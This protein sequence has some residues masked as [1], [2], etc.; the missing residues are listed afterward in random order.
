[1][2]KT[3]QIE[4]RLRAIRN[5]RTI[6]RTMEMIA[7]SRFRRVHRQSAQASPA[8]AKLE[9]A[10]RDA[11][12]A[13]PVEHPLL[14]PGPGQAAL[15]VVLTSNRGLCG[16]YNNRVI[17]AARE[18]KV[19]LARRGAPVQLVLIGK[20][21]VSLAAHRGFPAPVKTMPQF[22]Q[23]DLVP[24]VSALADELM[25]QFLAGE[26]ASVQ[27]VYQRRESAAAHRPCLA[28]LLPLQVKPPSA[29]VGPREFMPSR[30]DV[31]ATLLPMLVRLRLLR[32]VLDA[33][34]GEQLARMLAMRSATRNAEEAIRTLTR[35]MNRVRQTQIT[36]ELAEI[37]GGSEA[38]R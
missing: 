15:L 11:V 37:M 6:A 20:K 34:V 12:A 38:L 2:A 16:G 29:D 17:D 19:D 10:A 7:I 21:G 14:V 5:I 27:V 32:A 8:L 1:M 4:K 35:R 25:R 13:G 3:R 23:A 28:T 31:L 26:V 36:M 33:V 22:E 30:P 24:P 9:S 18:A